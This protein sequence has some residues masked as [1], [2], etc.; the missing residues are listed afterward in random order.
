MSEGGVQRDDSEQGFVG[1]L[2]DRLKSGAGTVYGEPVER[3]GV[4]VIPVACVL[5][6]GGGGSGSVGEQAG[7]GG[8]GGVVAWPSG[9]IEI[10]AGRARFKAIRRPWEWVPLVLAVTLAAVWLTK[11]IRR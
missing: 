4:T 6:G 9:Y 2:L 5:W 3:D 8:G 11:E 10:A 1:R 7:M